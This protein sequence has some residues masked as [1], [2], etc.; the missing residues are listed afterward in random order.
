MTPFP[1]VE[2][3]VKRIEE[4]PFVQEGLKVP[5]Q[6]LVT[7]IKGNPDLE[8]QIMERMKKAREEKEKLEDLKAS[9][10]KEEGKA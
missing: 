6:D 5:E 8:R 2:A 4:L 3:Y 1:N 9:K 7:R 10:G